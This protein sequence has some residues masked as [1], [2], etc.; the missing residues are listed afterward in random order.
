MRTVSRW[1]SASLGIENPGVLLRCAVLLTVSAAL[2]TH[3]FWDLLDS[4]KITAQA[5]DLPSP[6]AQH[7]P[8]RAQSLERLDTASINI[9]VESSAS[10]VQYKCTTEGLPQKA[11][12][13]TVWKTIDADGSLIST[14]H[15]VTL[16]AGRIDP[17]LQN[18]CQVLVDDGVFYNLLEKR[19]QL[20][21]PDEQPRD[22]KQEAPAFLDQRSTLSVSLTAGQ[23]VATCSFSEGA[24]ANA[25]TTWTLDDQ[26]LE[27]HT[28]S[29]LYL[30]SGQSGQLRCK[31]SVLE[32][33]DPQEV[34]SENLVGG[35]SLLYPTRG[36]R[37]HLFPAWLTGNG[38]ELSCAIEKSLRGQKSDAESAPQSKN[39]AGWNC[40]TWSH[41]TLQDFGLVFADSDDNDAS[42]MD[43]DLIVTAKRGSQSTS[44][45]TH[46]LSEHSP[47]RRMV[48][49]NSIR[50]VPG[51][52]D[53]TLVCDLGKPPGAPEPARAIDAHFRSVT[54]DLFTYIWLSEAGAI[55]QK[56]GSPSLVTQDLPSS[57]NAVRCFAWRT[58]AE[59]IFAGQSDLFRTGKYLQPLKPQDWLLW[60]SG[61]VTLKVVVRAPIKRAQAPR[62]LKL[63]C[64]LI[65]GSNRISADNFCKESAMR[66]DQVTTDQTHMATTRAD[67]TTTLYTVGIHLTEKQVHQF[68][69]TASGIS[70]H[71]R[72]APL[73]M[74]F[75]LHTQTP[76][77]LEGEQSITLLRSNHAP[78]IQNV[79]T[80]AEDGH[81]ICSASI[82][83]P[84]H[85]HLTA[86]WTSPQAPGQ[87]AILSTSNHQEGFAA[88]AEPKFSAKL[89]LTI[90]RV[91]ANAQA[92]VATQTQQ[93]GPA[94][95]INAA[96]PLMCNLTVS[97]GILI[98]SAPSHR[99]GHANALRARSTTHHTLKRTAQPERFP[100]FS[101]VP[102]RAAQK[103]LY[104]HL[105][106]INYGPQRLSFLEEQTFTQIR[107]CKGL[108]IEGAF[109]PPIQLKNG[110]LVLQVNEMLR[111]GLYAVWL[112]GT[113]GTQTLALID[114]IN[115]G[116]GGES[117]EVQGEPASCA[118]LLQAGRAGQLQ[119]SWLEIAE[120]TAMSKVETP[121]PEND[122]NSWT[123]FHPFQ[124]NW[125]TR[126]AQHK[127]GIPIRCRLR[128]PQESEKSK[129]KDKL[130]QTHSSTILT[131]SI[132]PQPVLILENYGMPTDAQG[133]LDDLLIKE[134]NSELPPLVH[135]H[136]A[137]L[138]DSSRCVTAERG[139]LPAL[140]GTGLEFSDSLLFKANFTTVTGQTVQYRTKV[141]TV[142]TQPKES[143]AYVAQLYAQ[144]RRAHQVEC[145]VSALGNIDALPKGPDPSA[146]AE[147]F[148]F[149]FLSL[150]R[151]V[152]T[153]RT[154]ARSAVA[155]GDSATRS[156]I[157]SCEVFRN[158]LR[159]AR[160]SLIP[161]E[162]F[163]LSCYAS[164]PGGWRSRVSCTFSGQGGW[165][166]LSFNNIKV[167][168]GALSESPLQ[169]EAY[170]TGAD[171][172]VEKGFVHKFEGIQTSFSEDAIQSD[173][174][175]ASPA[176]APPP[177][178]SEASTP[179]KGIPY[180]RIYASAEDLA[181]SASK[182][183]ANRASIQTKDSIA[184]LECAAPASATNE[185]AMIARMIESLSGS[186][187]GSDTRLQFSERSLESPYLLLYI[188]AIGKEDETEP[189]FLGVSQVPQ[190]LSKE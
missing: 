69:L 20:A 112:D 95:T 115:G 89:P 72:F 26:E 62:K 51:S 3:A 74:R 42:S 70:A 173:A 96:T 129:S 76:L 93:A 151:V 83:D 106:G 117:S 190:R 59:M 52:A 120:R 124:P 11:R 148:E 125:A 34:R 68:W 133:L 54:A 150:E 24:I 1:T 126:Q 36:Q 97:D 16:P 31:Y 39:E 123:L 127:Q 60:E 37:S 15:S 90:Q 13:L 152:Q 25:Q 143:F 149:R 79:E 32:W 4:E 119:G 17:R 170:W 66:L 45:T 18:V 14:L 6:S 180:V 92:I 12:V 71:D 140:V 177:G 144:E 141:A 165:E 167:N 172:A 105:T 7:R 169:F 9:K 159:V 19:L 109:C 137:D 168:L 61:D 30:D 131:G 102:R 135:L 154:L 48:H 142:S 158:G 136:S 103:I 23:K 153:Q 130:P 104:A 82:G 100:S 160:S 113:D 107:A 147:G 8:T 57:V 5:A 47:A 157:D 179:A 138:C 73:V 116:F 187:R 184:A 78:V 64:N 77:D 121:Y 55:L 111:H 186:A 108:Q 98:Q 114:V 10:N 156:L 122:E 21:S 28:H 38:S 128:Y 176:S 33:S 162:N 132:I 189:L 146:D 163:K 183:L 2:V 101:S 41:P 185:C 49:L 27:G 35:Q 94:G 88:V 63:A 43:A 44:I 164:I 86:E 171:G 91:R 40:A 166:R 67:Q 87:K 188:W 145:S 181:H 81:I 110:E 99:Q 80:R 174:S 58:T 75:L 155:K 118:I 85:D 161:P 134:Q 178:H 65:I 84:D 182:E 53:E 46:I 50:I 22:R 56:S 139:M 175:I 29:T